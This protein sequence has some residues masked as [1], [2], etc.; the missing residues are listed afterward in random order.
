MRVLRVA[1]KRREAVPSECTEGIAFSES[2]ALKRREAVP[3]EC[4]GWEAFSESAWI[5]KAPTG[6]MNKPSISSIIDWH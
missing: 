4:T 6:A 5:C 3:S 2:V 1:L